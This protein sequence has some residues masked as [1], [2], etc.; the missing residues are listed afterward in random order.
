YK[1]SG[2]TIMKEFWLYLHGLLSSPDS[3]KAIFLVEKI[4]NLGYQVEVMD[5]NPNKVAFENMT[6]EKEL[7]QIGN[8]I[9]KTGAERVSIIGSSFGA[10]LATL[11]A[12]INPIVRRLILLAPAFRISSSHIKQWN[13]SPYITQSKIQ[14]EHPRYGQVLM[15]SSIIKG[16]I[17]GHISD[18][19]PLRDIPTLI[20]IGKRDEVIDLDLVRGFAS[21]R[22]NTKV[23]ELDS[24]HRMLDM[25]DIM[26]SE[27]VDFLSSTI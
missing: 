22:M 9:N 12:A 26:A 21:K 2:N 23:I 5:R 20:L 27:I 4:R 18:D 25:L 14:L 24:D 17:S 11:F 7:A 3:K 8:E 6:I 1:T 15:E 19:F 13:K 16:L 10:M